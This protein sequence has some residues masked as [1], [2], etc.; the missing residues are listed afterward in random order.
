MLGL[1]KW[2]FEVNTMFFSGEITV[3][4]F[5]DSGKY[6]FELEKPNI[7]VPDISVKEIRE[8]GNS[9]FAS[10]QTSLLP[11]ATV[12]LNVVFDGDKFDGFVKIP[13]LGKVKLKNGRRIA[14]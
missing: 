1:G 11:G 14:Q 2:S 13:V 8:S 6:G 10:V 9:V 4:V 5:D 12:E 3:R 7:E